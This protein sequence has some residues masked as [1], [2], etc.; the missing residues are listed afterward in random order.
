MGGWG[1]RGGRGGRFGMAE[2]LGCWGELREGGLHPGRSHA[3]E[4]WCVGPA[5]AR[6]SRLPVHH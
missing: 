3:T 4:L 5:Q 1:E 2:G 6:L